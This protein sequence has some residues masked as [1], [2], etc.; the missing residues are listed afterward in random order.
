ML[1]SDFDIDERY[2]AHTLKDEPSETLIEHSNL[3]FAYYK[4]ILHIKNL[5]TLLSEIIESLDKENTKLI[6]EMFESAV[7]LHDIGKINPYFQ[8]KKMNNPLFSQYRDKTN[9]SDH[10]LLSSEK[11]LDF[12]LVKIVEIKDRKL[13]EKLKF[14]L[15]S[16]SY[17]I[18][19]HHGKLSIFEAYRPVL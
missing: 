1:L 11:Y 5:D 2:L 7:L 14:I 4:K 12:F 9:S 10:S 15:Y 19:K 17:H 6:R 18:A 3:T 8:A 16:F 13:R